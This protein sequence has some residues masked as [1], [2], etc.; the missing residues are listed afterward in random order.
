MSLRITHQAIA[1][2]ALRAE[3]LDTGCGAAVF[4]EGWVR[5]HNE[6]K[7]VDRLEYEVYE[8]LAVS[9]GEGKDG[10]LAASGSS[11]RSAGS[12]L[13]SAVCAPPQPTE[14]IFVGFVG[15]TCAFLTIHL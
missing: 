7:S 15:K 6:G 9:E 2:D 10:P 8:P 1:A 14:S 12:I 5:H 4:F 13:Q 3:L 11:S